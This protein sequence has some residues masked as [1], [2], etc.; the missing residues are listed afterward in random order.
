MAPVAAATRNAVRPGPAV[1]RPHRRRSRG[2]LRLHACRARPAAP[3]E[4]RRRPGDQDRR[5]AEA[6]VDRGGVRRDRARGVRSVV[7]ADVPDG[8]GRRAGAR[9]P[10][11]PA[12][13]SSPAALIGL[14]R[15]QSHGRDHQPD[16]ERCRGARH[17]DHRRRHLARSERDAA[18]RYGS[19]AVRARLAARA[20]DARRLP[21]DGARDGVV[22]DPLE[23]RL[24]SRAR[25]HRSRHR[26]A[27]RGHRGHAGRPVLCPRAAQPD[28]LPWHQHPLQ[29]RELRDDRAQ[30][31]LLPGR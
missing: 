7:A 11:D 28:E 5:P 31:A 22:Q 19:R 9:R 25:A 14:L 27:R 16:H 18:D 10:E 23:P 15:A 4:A 8:L 30:R 26:H 21:L 2:A 12:L 3:C 17:A 13:Q 24:P 6:R 29:G 20:R 1:P